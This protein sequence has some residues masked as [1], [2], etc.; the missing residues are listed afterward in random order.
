[1]ALEAAAQHRLQ[2]L[3]VAGVIHPASACRQAVL[4]CQ[5]VKLAGQG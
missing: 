1:M 3:H 2:Q 4:S 5:Q